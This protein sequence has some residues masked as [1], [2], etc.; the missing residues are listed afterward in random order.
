MGNARLALGQFDGAAEAYRAGLV[1][2]PSHSGSLWNLATALLGSGNLKQ[3]WAQYERRWSVQGVAP[4]DRFPFPLW[5]GEPVAGR[6]FL[7]WREQ[8]LGDELLFATCA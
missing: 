2:D 4:A 8:G 7:V 6:K 3:G 1:L 5:Q